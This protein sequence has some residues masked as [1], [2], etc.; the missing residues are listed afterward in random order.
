[1]WVKGK[2]KLIIIIEDNNNN[3]NKLKM[4]ICK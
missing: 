3:Y 2:K 1:M 4:I